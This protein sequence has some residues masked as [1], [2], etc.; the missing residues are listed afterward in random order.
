M[1]SNYLKALHIIFVTTWFAGLFYIVRLFIYHREAI[2]KPSEERKILIQQFS[3]M[4]K[5]LW[6]GITWPSCI[7]T[8]IFGFSMLHNFSPITNH[9]WL[10][11]KLIFV[12]LLFI[13][14]LSCGTILKEF[15]KNEYC[16]TSMQLRI[17]NEVATIFLVS[18]IFLVVLKDLLSFGYGLLGLFL[19]SFVLA[20][21]IKLYRKKRQH[22][23]TSNK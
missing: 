19:L 5:R 2:D 15:Q 7:L 6:Y 8:I 14:H 9:P 16:Y 11:V 22:N 20:I 10:I 12:V 18:I 4:E 23:E 21:G 1:D 17:W 3:I 13:Y